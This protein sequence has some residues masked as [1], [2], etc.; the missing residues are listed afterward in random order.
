MKPENLERR[1]ARQPFREVP[2]DWREGILAATCAE[3][4]EAPCRVRNTWGLAL[5]EI[6]WPAPRLWAAIACCWTVMLALAAVS[7]SPVGSPEP[8]ISSLGWN[9]R[10]QQKL[11]AELVA[12][13]CHESKDARP[14]REKLPNQPHSELN[15]GFSRG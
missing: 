7:A 3:R 13:P 2:K 15:H 4:L 12:L 9:L 10:Q 1:M 6:F 8:A 5:R 11:L 14:D